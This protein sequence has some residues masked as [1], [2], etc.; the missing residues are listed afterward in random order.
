MRRPVL[1]LLLTILGPGP[2]HSA[3]TSV[4]RINITAETQ[5]A[6]AISQA[7]KLFSYGE[8]AGRDRQV[9]DTIERALASEPRNYQLLWRSARSCYYAAEES[10]AGQK[11]ALYERGIKAAQAAVALEP[12]AAEGHFW[13]G[14]NYGGVGEQQGMFKALRLISKIR[15]EMEAVVRINPA[16]EEA[17]AFLALGELDRQLPRIMGGSTARSISYCERG[18]RLSPNNL[19]LKVS[20]AQGYLE[21]GRKDDAKRQLSEVVSRTVNPARAR[22]ERG[23]QEEARRLLAKM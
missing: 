1:I 18:L 21:T 16:Y 10:P 4:S 20:L 3:P 22:A 14:A 7:D 15:A 8:D 5:A 19:E 9:L 23:V 2:A 6:G 11:V 13:L 17:R 12:N